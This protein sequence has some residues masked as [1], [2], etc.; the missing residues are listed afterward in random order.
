[1]QTATGVDAQRAALA[2]VLAFGHD[3]QAKV[4]G[5]VVQSQS[6]PAVHCNKS[7][8]SGSCSC[9]A[10][11]CFYDLQ[12]RGVGVSGSVGIAVQTDSPATLPC[13]AGLAATILRSASNDGDDYSEANGLGA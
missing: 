2:D 4:G 7:C 9:G 12:W 8:I 10:S 5:C 13:V 1:M 3:L 6:T 11:Q